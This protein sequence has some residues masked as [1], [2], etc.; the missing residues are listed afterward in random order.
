MSNIG[1][2]WYYNPAEQS[3]AESDRILF[4]DAARG[5]EFNSGTE[6]PSG[7]Q[8]IRLC[9]GANIPTTPGSGP[10]EGVF[11]CSI[12]GDSGSPVSVGIYYAGESLKQIQFSKK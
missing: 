9:R 4:R 6:F 11:T 8:N 12:D 10:L 2:N 3:T 1:S 7:F 5:W